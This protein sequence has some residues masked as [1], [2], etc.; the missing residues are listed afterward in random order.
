MVTD[1]VWRDVD[2]YGRLDL[3]VVGEW[4]A[5][6]IFHNAGGGKLVRVNA[7]GLEQS[8]GWWNRII[9]G[10]FTGHGRVDFIAGNLGTNTR[11]HAT[12]AEPM[13]MVVK[14]FD[15]NGSDEQIISLYNQGVSY[16]LPMRDDL[17]R[18]LPYLK[19][20][21]LNYKNYAKQ[22]LTDIFTPEELAGAIHKEARTLTT[23]LI[24]NNGDGSF[25]IVPLPKEAQLA[26]VY[27][28]LA[29]D[30]DGD[31]KTDLLL[32]GNFDGVKPEIGR[33]A[34]SWGLFL[35]GDGAGRFTALGPGESG[36]VAPGQARDIQRVR[37]RQGDLY[38]VAR[39]N[40]HPLIFRATRP[41]VLARR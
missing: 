20:R 38:V 28:I 40:D 3:V 5:I 26:P 32:A 14:D 21:Y 2:G 13:T 17:I 24:R 34:A 11:L 4:M 29:Q 1:A 6:T 36:F 7:P 27:G 37:T 25:T 23:S 18:A 8:A 41:R 30:F 22:T 35:S 31:G 16:P 39:N 12:P 9:A 33:M 10:D 15:R 19:A